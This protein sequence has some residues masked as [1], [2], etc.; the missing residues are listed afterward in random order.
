MTRLDWRYRLLGRIPML[1][2]DHTTM[3]D[4]NR[5]RARRQRPSR[6]LSGRPDPDVHTRTVEVPSTGAS[7]RI[8]ID[9]P[10][11]PRSGPRPLLVYVHGGGWMFCDMNTPQW[12]TTR[13]ASTTGAVVASIDYRLAPEHPFPAALDDCWTALVWLAE[14]AATLGADAELIAVMG[15]SAG[16]N[17]SA[18]LCLIA[19]DRGRPSIIHQ[20]LIYP[21]LDLTWSSPSMDTEGHHRMLD[22][23]QLDAVREAYIGSAD[24]ADW[25]ISPLHA[26][27][28]RGLPPAH[29]VVAEHDTLR[30]DGIRYAERLRAHGVPVRLGNYTG[31]AHGFLA[32]SLTPTMRRQA[33]ADMAGELTTAFS[34]R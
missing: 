22:R 25:R 3:T 20:T 30:D 7:V 5:E 34:V 21:A 33:L 24:A 8:R 23:A 27:D 18:V 13:L 19:R 26:D 10:A 32:L 12:L 1:N 2:P 9:E 6:W 29:I 15:D 4:A 31:M 16:G 14:H 11:V 28:L 17:L